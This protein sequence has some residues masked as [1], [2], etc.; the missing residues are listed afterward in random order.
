MYGLSREINSVVNEDDSVTV[1][2]AAVINE[3]RN[4][5]ELYPDQT[6]ELSVAMVVYMLGFNIYGIWKQYSTEI[7][8]RY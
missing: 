5:V 3:L 4:V 1:P 7:R 6:E 8:N 2:E